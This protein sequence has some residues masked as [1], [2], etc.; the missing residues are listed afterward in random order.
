MLL[1]D[2]TLEVD[3]VRMLQFDQ[4]GDLS[5]GGG[6]DPFFIAFQADFLHSNHLAGLEIAALVNDSISS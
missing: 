5:D 3:N 1:H 4:H 2:D 6:R